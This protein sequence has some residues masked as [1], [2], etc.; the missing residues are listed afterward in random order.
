[1]RLRAGAECKR[2]NCGR[3]VALHDDRTAIRR[4]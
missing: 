4:G 2:Q 1:L 3:A